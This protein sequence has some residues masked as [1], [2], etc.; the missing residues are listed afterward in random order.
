[1]KLLKIIIA[2]SIAV[3]FLSCNKEENDVDTKVTGEELSDEDIQ[4]TWVIEEEFFTKT[5][6]LDNGS[7]KLHYKNHYYGGHD[8]YDYYGTYSYSDGVITWNFEQVETSSGKQEYKY[9]YSGKVKGHFN[10]SVLMIEVPATSTTLLGSLYMPFGNKLYYGKEN[11]LFYYKENA[12]L[13]IKPDSIQGRWLW[14]DDDKEWMSIEFNG[15]EYE[16]IIMSRTRYTGTFS[17]ENGYVRIKNVKYSRASIENA[18]GTFSWV[19]ADPNVTYSDYY[20]RFDSFTMPFLL[21]KKKVAY[22]RNLNVTGFFV[23]Q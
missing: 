13:A 23:K 11:L 16:I 14:K 6:F 21:V 22:S 20:S 18:D 8:E 9:S 19:D 5:L 10:K 3:L 12:N 7:F 4:G 1:M 17:Y 15:N 2:A